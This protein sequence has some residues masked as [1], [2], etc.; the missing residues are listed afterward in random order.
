MPFGSQ[1]SRGQYADQGRML[2]YGFRN[3]EIASIVCD[4]RPAGIDSGKEGIPG[5][6]PQFDRGRV[7]GTKVTVIIN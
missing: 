2:N 7:M 5:M 1:P 3:R 6:A 4:M